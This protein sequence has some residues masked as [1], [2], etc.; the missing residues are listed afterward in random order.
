MTTP[1]PFHVPIS[2][3]AVRDFVYSEP[4][5][6]SSGQVADEFGVAPAVARRYLAQL[7]DAGTLARTGAK[8]GTRYSWA[9]LVPAPTRAPARVARPTPAQRTTA[10]AVRYTGRPQGDTGSDPLANR[11]KKRAGRKMKRPKA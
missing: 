7:V 11:R 8:R 9:P 10:R 1:D 5:P 3:G 6:V 4:R 2:A